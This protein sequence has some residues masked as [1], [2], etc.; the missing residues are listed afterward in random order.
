MPT[1]LH[2][3]LAAILPGNK[4]VYYTHKLGTIGM[5]GSYMKHRSV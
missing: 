1:A 5:V 4:L 2:D 3:S